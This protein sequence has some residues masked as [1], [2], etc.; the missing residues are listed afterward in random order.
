M[1]KSDYQFISIN[2]YGDSFGIIKKVSLEICQLLGY[3]DIDLIGK[4]MN[5]IIPDFIR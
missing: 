3:S 4:N 5:I 2:A 1:S